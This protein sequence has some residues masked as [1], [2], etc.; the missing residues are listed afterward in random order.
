M[1]TETERDTE[2]ETGIQTERE[3]HLPNNCQQE[4][5]TRATAT[6]AITSAVK[7]RLTGDDRHPVK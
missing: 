1:H 6:A 5:K 7:N 3:L 2:R 4:P